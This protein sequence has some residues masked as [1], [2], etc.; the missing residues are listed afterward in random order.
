MKE[1][2]YVFV[3]LNKAVRFSQKTAEFLRYFLTKI[4]K[5]IF[6]RYPSVLLFKNLRFCFCGEGGYERSHIG[7]Y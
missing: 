6:P 4:F 3:S 2:T 1:S 5:I 7:I